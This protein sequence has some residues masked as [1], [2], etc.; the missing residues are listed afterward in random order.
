MNYDNMSYYAWVTCTDCI[1]LRWSSLV[2]VNCI[3][4]ARRT[5]CGIPLT[6]NR[7]VSG[8]TMRSH[9]PYWGDSVF[10]SFFLLNP[11]QPLHYNITVRFCLWHIL[12]KAL[13]FIT[14]MGDMGLINPAYMH[15]PYTIVH[16]THRG[17]NESTSHRTT[18]SW[19]S[20]TGMTSDNPGCV[21]ILL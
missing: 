11:F 5:V 16:L 7:M 4:A 6:Q 18:A 1:I 9:V 17:Y 19:R 8:C 12:S 14:S 2:C 15:G 20:S 10:F 13:E 3:C 21:D